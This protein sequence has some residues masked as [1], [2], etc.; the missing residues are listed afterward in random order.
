MKDDQGCVEIYVC[1]Q[2]KAGWV[3]QNK[4]KKKSVQK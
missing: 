1:I 2:S 3:E 4:K